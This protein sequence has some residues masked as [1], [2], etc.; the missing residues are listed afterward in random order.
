MHF[1]LRMHREKGVVYVGA[2]P[3]AAPEDALRKKF[4]GDYDGVLMVFREELE[5]WKGKEEEVGEKGF[6]MYELFR[7]TVPKGEGGWGKKGVLDL[8]EARKVVGGDA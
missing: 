8:E 7:P 1:K 2:H 6:G 4:D 3:Q 5:R